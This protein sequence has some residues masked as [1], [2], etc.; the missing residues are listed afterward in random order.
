MKK[1]FFTVLGILPAHSAVLMSEDFES[2]DLAV[3]NLEAQTT[4]NWITDPIETPSIAVLGNASGSPVTFGSKSL[5]VGGLPTDGSEAELGVAYALAPTGSGF[6]PANY[7]LETEMSFSVDLILNSG[8][9]QSL[10]DDFRFSFFDLSNN[11]LA[12][13]LFTNDLDGNGNVVDGFAT[14]IRSNMT[15]AGVFD[16]QALIPLN[17]VF[18]LNLVLSPLLNKWSGSLSQDGLDFTLFANVDL[19]QNQGPPVPEA[20]VGAF[21]LDWLKGT[22]Q[23]DW[24][25]N[26]LIADNFLLQS[27]TPVPEPSVPLLVS[28]F[29]MTAFLRRRR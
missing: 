14:I 1:L 19:T 18:T 4:G 7:G 21:G 13:L 5:V 12:T 9:G 27:Q 29:A 8:G 22:G 16:T 24:G 17:T 15:E 3:D 28:A 26:Y 20:N 25:T 11:P 6:D 2:Y 23:P 10:T